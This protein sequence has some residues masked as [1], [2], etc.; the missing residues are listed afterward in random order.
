MTP[1][2]EEVLQQWTER[3]VRAA[4]GADPCGTVRADEMPE[5]W[6]RHRWF[7][8]VVAE[9]V[10]VFALRRISETWEIAPPYPDW[11]GYAPVIRRHADELTMISQLPH[12]MT[13]AEWFSENEPLLQR[14]PDNREQN[15]VAA[16]ALLPLF[17]AEP[18]C[19]EA[20]D[21][22]DFDMSRGSFTEFL[23]DWH[24]RVPKR[25]RSFVRRVAQEFG[26]EI[27]G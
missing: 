9:I 23:A 2:D 22:L 26:L 27:G 6:G 16:A 25:C 24:A 21:R 8:E 7:A 19:W 15:L 1:Y 17:V 12:G 18:H 3:E 11:Q 4:I 5:P 10:G 13:L 20:T 14:H